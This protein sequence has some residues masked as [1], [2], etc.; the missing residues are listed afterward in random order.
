MLNWMVGLEVV[1]KTT[2]PDVWIYL[3]LWSG[4]LSLR[5]L[6]G[7]LSSCLEGESKKKGK[8]RRGGG[9]GKQ[10]EGKSKNGTERR[11]K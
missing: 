3:C 4:R 7:T 2:A 1:L 11:E 9:G 10:A 8:A 6:S 5:L